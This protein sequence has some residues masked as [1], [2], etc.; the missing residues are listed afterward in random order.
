MR[1]I[2]LCPL[3]YE[4]T[5][6][7]KNT[8][9][10]STIQYIIGSLTTDIRNVEKRSIWLLSISQNLLLWTQFVISC[11]ASIILV[12]SGWVRYIVRQWIAIDCWQTWIYPPLRI[13]LFTVKVNLWNVQMVVDHVSFANRYVTCLIWHTTFMYIKIVPLYFVNCLF[14]TSLDRI[15][16]WQWVSVNSHLL[17]LCVDGL[18]QKGKSNLHYNMCTTVKSRCGI[19]DIR[20]CTP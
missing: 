14:D 11:P 3:K 19:N 6:S 16:Y 10:N 9:Q 4:W 7:S 1:V 20:L 17:S 12:G 8:T 18:Y 15:S 2:W 5:K 13:T